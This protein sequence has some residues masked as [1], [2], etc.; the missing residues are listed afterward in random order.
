MQGRGH[1]LLS[2][3]G[4]ADAGVLYAAHLARYA[5]PLLLYPALSRRLG[6][7]GLGLYVAAVALAL[8]VSVVVD[9]GVS[10][11]GPRD[12]AR[13]DRP[14]GLVV[15]QV[16]AMRAALIAPAGLAGLAVAGLTPGLQHQGGVVVMAIALG[17]AQGMSV[18]WYFQGVRDPAPAAVL[19]VGTVLASTVVIL[20]L[21]EFGVTAVL[22]IQALGGWAAVILGAGLMLRRQRPSPPSAAAVWRGLVEGAPLMA[23]RAVIV[24]YT[25][26]AVLVVGG[27]AGPAQAA[28]YG[29][30]DR[31]VSASASLM[32]PLAGVIAPRI[33]GLLVRDLATAFR[34]VRWS[35]ILLPGAFL[36]AAILLGLAAAPLVRLLFGQPF[37]EAAN[38]LRLLALSLPLIAVSQVLGLQL[39]TPLRMDGRFALVVG[40]GCVATL[41]SAVLFTPPLGAMGMALARV[42]GEAVVVVVCLACLRMHWRAL[43]PLARGRDVSTI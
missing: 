30:A 14:Q 25:G 29:V 26:A 35:L 39:M 38:V 40:V 20:I 3:K 27:L 1:R 37:A 6:V 21:P 8:I 5:S 43:W 17:A 31:V 23:S 19:E 28:L 18:L 2:R 33:A 15:G 10:I 41:G 9:Y 7:E 36:A 12:I 4:A 42:M 32:R 24:A 22:A 11:S 16:L 34:T 13:A